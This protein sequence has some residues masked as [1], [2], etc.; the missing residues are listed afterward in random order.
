MCLALLYGQDDFYRTLQYA[1][2]LG[3]DADCN[4]ATAGTVVGVRLGFKCIAALPQFKMPDLYVNKSRPQLPAECKVS[5]QVD[6][7][8][9]ITE[10]VILTNGGER[11]TVGGQPGFRVKIQQPRLLEPLPAVLHGPSVKP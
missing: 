4:A 6:T 2:A 11:V 9:R 1:M 8:A 7:L 5:K 3:H 10:R